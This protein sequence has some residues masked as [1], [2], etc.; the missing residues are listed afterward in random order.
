MAATVGKRGSRMDFSSSINE[1]IKPTT[2]NHP[3]QDLEPKEE[4]K[5]RC[6]RPSAGEVKRISLA[7]PMDMVDGIGAAA[8]LFYKG[9]V[10]SY[11]N[12]LIKKDLDENMEKYEAFQM[13]V[14]KK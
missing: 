13:M 10:T 6:G 12:A 7:I 1:T 3:A 5:K 9:N 2:L 14:A 8:A 11:I 4:K